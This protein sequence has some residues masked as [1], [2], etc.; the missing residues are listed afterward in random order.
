MIELE[1]QMGWVFLEVAMVLAIAA[2][3]VWW[4]MPKAPKP[5]EGAGELA[6]K[7]LPPRN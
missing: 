4:T 3:I 7:D 5:K 2:G 1:R 6:N